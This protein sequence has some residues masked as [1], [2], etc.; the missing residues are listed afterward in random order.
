MHMLTLWTQVFCKE[1]FLMPENTSE[2]ILTIVFNRNFNHYFF[3]KHLA[4]KKGIEWRSKHNI[5]TV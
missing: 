3:S 1:K 2:N 5:L 4:I